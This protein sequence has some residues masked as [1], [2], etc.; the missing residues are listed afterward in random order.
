[1]LKNLCQSIT[2]SLLLLVFLF[3]AN[4]VWAQATD[5]AVAGTLYRQ[6]EQQMETNP[7]DAQLAIG[8]ALAIYKQAGD[9]RG[10]IK[11]EIINGKLILKLSD[12]Y[13][14]RT[15]L[16]KTVDLARS[17]NDAGLEAEALLELSMTFS[18]SGEYDQAGELVTQAMQLAKKTKNESLLCQALT[19]QGAV[20][21]N[22]GL[23]QE[24]ESTFRKALEI[25]VRIR[26]PKQELRLLTN[27]AISAARKA[28]YPNAIHRFREAMSKA[29]LLHNNLALARVYLNLGNTYLNMKLYDSSAHYSSLAQELLMQSGEWFTLSIAT[30]N[31]GE[32]YLGLKQFQTAESL[33]I[34]ARDTAESH[35]NVE[36]VYT[37]WELLS[38]IYAAWGKT[39]QAYEALKKTV[40]YK[41]SFDLES[42]R[43][44]V[45]RQELKAEYEL[46]RQKETQEAEHALQRQKQIRNVFFLSSLFILI[47]ALLIWN[48]RSR[49][50]K[51]K[52]RSDELLLNILPGEIATE[53]KETGKAK[54]N[55]F[56]NTTVL[57]TDF[58]GFTRVSESMSAEHLVE[59]IDYCFRN[60]DMII[61][62][63]GLEKIKTV[64]DAYLAVSGLPV[65]DAAH[66]DR[67][68]RT[69]IAIRNFM[70]E[71]QKQRA[72]ATRISFE[73]RIGVHSGPVVAGVVGLKKFSYD[74]WGDTVNTAARM[75]ETG[76]PGKVNISGATKSLLS[77]AF[78]CEYRG[79]IQ[80]KNKGEM[81]MYFA[82]LQS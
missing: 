15:E 13:K 55:L 75:E 44:A 3:G 80:A 65:P 20:Y 77:S 7:G 79:K 5:T 81:D 47:I 52:A 37:T 50:K 66:A 24:A 82:E 18:L 33:A 11:S 36:M 21:D 28:D 54:A 62:A 53:L 25:A 43:N 12:P 9:I 73:M 31:H 41:D 56:E 19:S 16:T 27:L 14:A 72:A 35:K 32:A 17:V 64:G 26:S 48:Q 61:E 76:V 6:A 78:V 45:K 69:A 10:Q 23:Q 2:Y 30:A 4:P 68:V 70:L 22:L 1:M 74:I 49:I 67:V 60:F 38:R 63:N 46:R 34:Q 58:V 40:A 8:K 59:E 39:N 71:Y 51:E 57:F 29:S 42:Q